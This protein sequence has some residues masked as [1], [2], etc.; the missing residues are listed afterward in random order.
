[1]KKV[2]IIL[3]FFFAH[4]SYA[5]T[6]RCGAVNHHRDDHRM[7][8]V[9]GFE[10]WMLEKQ[11]VLAEQF[12][13][14][15]AADPMEIPV[16]FH[17]IHNGEAIGSG[18]NISDEQ[19]LSQLEVLNEDFQRQNED[20]I[21]TRQQF[22]SVAADFGIKFV[23]AKQD[24]EGNATNGITRTQTDITSF[25]INSSAQTALKSLSYWNSEDY[26]N[27]WVANLSGQLLGYASWPETDIPGPGAPS[28]PTED[29]VVID[30][31]VCGSNAKGNF[32]TIDPTYNLGRTLSHEIGHFFGLLHI[33]GDGGCGV[34]DFCGDTPD[35][36]S[37]TTTS[38]DQLQDNP[39]FSCETLDQYEN[40][41]DYTPDACMNMF[42]A[43]Q[44]SR[45]EVVLEFSPRRASLLSSPGLVEPNFEDN[46]IRLVAIPSPK[47]VSCAA[48]MPLVLEVRNVGTNE[49]NSMMVELTFGEYEAQNTIENLK[50]APG[51]NKIL[52]TT[53]LGLPEGEKELTAIVTRVN[54]ED[55]DAI[56]VGRLKK[57]IL[58][59]QSEA[60]MPF[61]TAFNS[62]SIVSEGW[63]PFPEN[64][65]NQWEGGQTTDQEWAALL[66]SGSTM[67]NH[68][69][70]PLILL[71]ETDSLTITFETQRT[72]SGTSETDLNLW[73][74]NDCGASETLIYSANS[75]DLKP[76]E[77]HKK[78]VRHYVDISP[79]QEQEV[80]L[81][82]ACANPNGGTLYLREFRIFEKG[83]HQLKAELEESIILDP[84]KDDILPRFVLSTSGSLP[85]Q[86]ALVYELEEEGPIYLKLMAMD[87]RLLQQYQKQNTLQGSIPIDLNNLASGYY[88]LEINSLK[89]RT[90]KRLFQP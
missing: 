29:G 35:Q 88:L 16:V 44:K 58:V 2:L 17:I 60:E 18:K 80:R 90:V 62:A 46:A 24:P 19:I 9:Q 56:V 68:L 27:I 45:V 83:K 3:L 42:T 82:F 47:S 20:A 31:T 55:N 15:N 49:V 87:G 12:P 67:V 71:S 21:N 74:S 25:G 7:A 36:S 78:W 32:P 23:M 57:T 65:N 84:Q 52:S 38:C 11:R 48:A 59:D 13:Q 50:L 72:V 43:D 33:W 77:E 89:G 8:P 10:S 6:D 66:R 73:I 81:D 30:F 22:L 64:S 75:S 1:M 53:L 41:M 54:N 14:R 79:F 70:S 76:S 37:Q 63:I 40:F 28:A 85:I 61:Y 26:L 4:W 69:I 86:Y 5:Q 51:E 34:D 39:P